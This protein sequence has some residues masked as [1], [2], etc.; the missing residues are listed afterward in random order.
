M[1]RLRD[2]KILITGPAG[3]IAYP[4]TAWLAADNEVW[5]IA[6]FGNE[7]DRDRVEALGVTTRRCDIAS[8]DFDGVPDDFTHVVHLAA[9]QPPGLDYDEAIRVNA[10]GTGLLLHHCRRAEA[11]LVMST[12]SVYRPH[13]DP[14][15]V[16]GESDPLG[17][18]SP[19]HSPTYS[20]SKLTQEAVARSCA[21]SLGLPVTIA[22]MN[23]SYGPNGGLV[24]YHLDAVAAGQP[25]TTR[26]DPCRY[27]PI[28]Q[29]DINLQVG[30]LLVA[31]SVPATIVNWAG[32]EVVTVQEWC[33]Y[34]ASL[35]GTTAVVDVT[36]I[37]GTLRGSV[38]DVTRRAA[39]TG[40]CTVG[41]QEGIRR[42]LAGRV[43]DWPGQPGRVSDWR[44]PGGPASRQP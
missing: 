27:S 41:W 5:G 37:P 32:D 31:A 11:A 26:W 12:H 7:E 44:E 9:A 33:G 38:A 25:V 19:T 21:R 43:S 1:P 42:T 18:A 20:V 4:L 15:H 22:R 36:E 10:E 29:D 28:F 6:R 13:P 40:P 24:A 30:D 35:L 2:R 8:G 34:A 23:A 3:Q 17:D 39:I 14:E 16:F